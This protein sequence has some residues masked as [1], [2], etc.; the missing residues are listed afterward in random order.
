MLKGAGSGQKLYQT[1]KKLIPGGTQLLSKR[2]ELF[3]P[4]L[5]PAY[6]RKASGCSVWDLDGIRYT[7]MSYMGIGSCIL[8][9]ADPDVNAAVKQAVDTGSMSTL[10]ATEE[11]ELAQLLIK[12]HPWAAMVRYARSGGESMHGVRVARSFM[13]RTWCFFSGYYGWMTGNLAATW[14]DSSLDGNAA[15]SGARGVP[16]ALK[17]A[18]SV[19]YNINGEF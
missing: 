6:Y 13:G 15:G 17:R 4:G 14:R 1:A 16:A 3:L 19:H 18:R 2:P 8:G 7:D 10:N 11:V 9:Y 5:W 12:L